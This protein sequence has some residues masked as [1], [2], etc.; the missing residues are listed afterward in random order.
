MANQKIPINQGYSLKRL[1]PIAGYMLVILL[2]DNTSASAF[3]AS[4]SV[5]AGVYWSVSQ[6]YVSQSQ[7]IKC[8]DEQLS[9]DLSEELTGPDGNM[10]GTQSIASLPAAWHCAYGSGIT[11]DADAGAAHGRA[12]NELKDRL[13]VTVPAG[14]YDQD[15]VVGLRGRVSGTFTMTG[16]GSGRATYDACFTAG[17]CVDWEW[18]DEDGWAFSRNY[19]LTYRLVTAGTTLTEP[20]VRTINFQSD[21]SINGQSYG[22]GI[23]S[24]YSEISAGLHICSSHDIGWTSDS[25]AFGSEALSQGDNNFD[26]D[27]DGSDLAAFIGDFGRQDCID[28]C[29]GDFDFD[30]A[31]DS[32]DLS[33]IAGDYGKQE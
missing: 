25:G 14:T 19:Y 3:C 8:V 10:G 6:G 28:D 23:N 31:V 26:G 27:V 20:R 16:D 9:I 11:P 5:E 32:L 12:N 13:L 30:G 1:L 15:V 24:G 22:G 7:E 29:D 18:E 17:N 2:I 21:L 4:G 33:V